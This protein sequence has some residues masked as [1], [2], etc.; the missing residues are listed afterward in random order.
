MTPNIKKI[1]VGVIVTALIGF[2]GYAFFGKTGP[3]IITENTEGNMS[4]GEVVGQD[5]LDLVDNLNKIIIDRTVFSSALFF[6]LI[7]F[8][9]TLY[10]ESLGRTNPFAPIGSDQGVTLNTSN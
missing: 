8:S 4:E 5:I 7:D 10:P 9:A 2:A 1:I 6:N 3:V